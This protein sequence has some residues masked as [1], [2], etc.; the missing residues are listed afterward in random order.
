MAAKK[1]EIPADIA[2]LSFEVALSQLEEIVRYLESGEAEL[3]NRID[4]YERGN[5][6]KAHCEAR[7]Q[8]AQ[9]KVEKITLSA[10]GDVGTEPANIE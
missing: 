5:Q 10:S 1:A 8:A 3:E 6:L 2:K 4:L 7:L 9:A